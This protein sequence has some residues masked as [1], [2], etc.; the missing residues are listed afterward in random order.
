CYF[1]RSRRH[2]PARHPTLSGSG[3]QQQELY[4]GS[5]STG[6]QQ[7][8]RS[9]LGDA[10]R[11]AWP[12]CIFLA[13]VPYAVVDIDDD[14]GKVN[15][16]VRYELKLYQQYLGA[17]LPAHSL[18]VNNATQQ[19]YEYVDYGDLI[20]VYRLPGRGT[21]ALVRQ[22][23]TKSKS[24]YVIKG[25]DF[26]D[27]LASWDDFK[28]E[29]DVFYHAVQIT[30]SMPSH[31]N[32]LS[33]PRIIVVAGCPEDEGRALVCGTLYPFM[34][35]GTLDDQITRCKKDGSHLGLRDKA[36]WCLQ[37][38]SAV[39]HAHHVAHTYHMDIK[40][41][42]I[43]VDDQ[44][45]AVLIDWEQSGS[46]L[47]TLAPEAN[48]EWDVDVVDIPGAS[49]RL[50]YSRYQ[51]PVRK[52]LPSSRPAWNV[53]P[54]WSRQW[55]RACEAA[56]VFSLGRTMWMLLQ[57]APQEEVEYLEPEEIIVR[58]SDDA[59]NIPDSWKAVVMHCLE[60]DP[61][62]RIGLVDLVRFWE[63]EQ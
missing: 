42:N 45:N 56:E 55:P 47:Y 13:A 27:L 39:A 10:A 52:N 36:R 21:S 35:R 9:A 23:S 12:N 46:P 22:A 29:R 11:Q 32:I 57:E 48:G 37:M 60:Q 26:G 63:E 2:D 33:P 28:H 53:F 8:M 38:S 15:W 31:P 50:V 58:W 40:P 16:I 19:G 7:H 54:E 14:A 51:G 6:S 59:G 18:L 5:A 25:L 1:L 61:N 49:T 30:S 17:L 24:L 41:A 43:L 3:S 62:K 34:A 4:A 44:E 20:I